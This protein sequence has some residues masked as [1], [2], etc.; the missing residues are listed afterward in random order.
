MTICFNHGGD[1]MIPS[2]L[3]PEAVDELCKCLFSVFS[4]LMLRQ[5]IYKLF[6]QL[7]SPF[8]VSTAMNNL[9]RNIV[10]VVLM[11][12]RVFE[13]LLANC[14]SLLSVASNLLCSA[15]VCFAYRTRK[16]QIEDEN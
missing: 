15:A 11:A 10:G 8:F 12:G 7:F 9:Q 3:L 13:S 1:L 4:F 6:V 14:H 16:M 5:P 2:R